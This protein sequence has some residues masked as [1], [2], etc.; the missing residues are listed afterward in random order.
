MVKDGRGGAALLQ[1]LNYNFD[2]LLPQAHKL[3]LQIMLFLSLVV[4][5]AAARVSWGG[6]L[7][8]HDKVNGYN[9]IGDVDNDD[10]NTTHLQSFPRNWHH[11]SH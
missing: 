10:D 4:V 11:L 2:A 1:I 7:I 8:G 3:F 5:V 6:N 9:D